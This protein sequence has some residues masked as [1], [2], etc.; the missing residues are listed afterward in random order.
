[1]YVQIRK[2]SISRI[3]NKSFNTFINYWWEIQ[4]W[5][6]FYFSFVQGFT[7]PMILSLHRY[8]NLKQSILG[9]LR[10]LRNNAW[11]CVRFT[12][13]GWLGW[14]WI[15]PHSG[16]WSFMVSW[17]LK[18]WDKF[19]YSEQ[20]VLWV[21]ILDANGDQIMPQKIVV[22]MNFKQFYQIQICHPF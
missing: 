1:M 13:P 14:L 6:L 10:K 5:F 11:K 4:P 3:Y 12:L 2:I 22:E 9:G 8:V 18:I 21:K 17:H 15:A 16:T 7:T 19:D 20:N